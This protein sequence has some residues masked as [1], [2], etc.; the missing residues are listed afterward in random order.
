MC[1]FKNAADMSTYLAGGGGGAAAPLLLRV[2]GGGGLSPLLL[3][4]GGGAEPPTFWFGILHMAMH[5]C[6][7]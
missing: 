3:R 5:E 1:G 2:G 4:V 6:R 7:L